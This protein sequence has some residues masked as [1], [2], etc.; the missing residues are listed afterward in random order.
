MSGVAAWIG[1]GIAVVGA[2]ASFAQASQAKSD[3]E[4]A[5]LE[6]DKKMKAARARLEKNY[7]QSLS[8]PTE[9]Y[10][11]E[12]EA[13]LVQGATAMQAAVEGDQRGA[14]A[15]ASRVL[16][17][18]Q[19]GQAA[20]RTAMAKD[21][22]NLEAATAEEE[23]RLRDARASIDIAEAEGAQ[24]ASQAAEARRNAAISQGIQQTASAASQSIAASDLYKTSQENK[25][26]DTLIKSDPRFQQKIGAKY[27]QTT[28]GTGDTAQVKNIADL[29]PLEFRDY[30]LTNFS[31]NDLKAQDLAYLSPTPPP[32]T[33]GSGFSYNLANPNAD[34]PWEARGLT[35]AQWNAMMGSGASFNPFAIK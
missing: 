25:Q 1:V 21:I 19:E 17:Y 34:N 26:I 7:M 27:G 22:F 23:S 20:Q 5:E 31:L 2:T 24:L 33:D 32:K 3:R 29:S 28:I 18:Q 4:E 9:A 8:I 11:R 12:R 10:E 14:G 35:E 16:Q 6:A 13:L 15:V 30:L